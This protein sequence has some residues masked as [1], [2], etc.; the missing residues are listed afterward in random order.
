MTMKFCNDHK[1]RIK[2]AGGLNLTGA[3]FKDNY[4]KIFLL[5]KITRNFNEEDKPSHSVSRNQSHNSFLLGSQ[6]LWAESEPQ[7]LHAAIQTSIIQNP[8]YLLQ[9][10]TELT[11]MRND[12]ILSICRYNDI[13]KRMENETERPVFKNFKRIK[14]RMEINEA[15]FV[16]PSS[17]S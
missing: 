15:G 16:T 13:R 1:Y 11:N 9:A 3:T 14:E 7:S 8:R 6:I 12:C 2:Q 5:Q 17:N 10:D 4:A